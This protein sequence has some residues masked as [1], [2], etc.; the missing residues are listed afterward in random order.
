MPC[1]FALLDP[2]VTV[3]MLKL[4][5]ALGVGLLARPFPLPFAIP[6]GF[7]VDP[8]LERCPNSFVLGILAAEFSLLLVGPNCRESS[9]LLL[10]R[11][12]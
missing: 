5:V 8:I 9:L 12:P 11:C 7:E 2:F 6:L 3:A 10:C 1:F 4:L